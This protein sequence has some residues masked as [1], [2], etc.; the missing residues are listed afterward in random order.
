M[1]VI[2]I[3]VT[4]IILMKKVILNLVNVFVK[5]YNKDIIKLLSRFKNFSFLSNM[6]V[7]I[8]AVNLK[9]IMNLSIIN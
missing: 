9:K 2:I 7:I 1:I 6:N 3:L 8:F 5:I 4:Y